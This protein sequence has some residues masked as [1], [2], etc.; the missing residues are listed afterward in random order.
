MSFLFNV[1]AGELINF[2]RQLHR[3]DD[4]RQIFDGGRIFSLRI[5][6]HIK[7]NFARRLNVAEFARAFNF[8]ANCPL[9]RFSYTF[10]H[11]IIKGVDALAAHFKF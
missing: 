2:F 7:I 8:V 5:S 9:E 11:R 6:A 4:L 10:S 1:R 3:T